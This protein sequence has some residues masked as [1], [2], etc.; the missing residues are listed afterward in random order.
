[1]HTVLLGESVHGV[2]PVRFNAIGK[3]AGYAYVQR[4]VGFAGEDVDHRLLHPA[5]N[6]RTGICV[7]Y[8]NDSG[9]RKL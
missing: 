5:S 4:S 3:V 1:M 6:A 8:N 7:D 9:L 2:V